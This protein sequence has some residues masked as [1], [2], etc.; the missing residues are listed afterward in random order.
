MIHTQNLLGSELLLS[1]RL[2]SS[3]ELLG[4]IEGINWAHLEKAIEDWAMLA[5]FRYFDVL[6]PLKLHERFHNLKCILSLASGLAPI[7]LNLVTKLLLKL[8][9]VKTVT[10]VSVDKFFANLTTDNMFSSFLKYH[11]FLKK[12]PR[13]KDINIELVNGKIEDPKVY[14]RACEIIKPSQFGCIFLSHPIVLSPKFAPALY[15]LPDYLNHLSENGCFIFCTYT[16]LECMTLLALLNKHYLAGKLPGFTVKQYHQDNI[17]PE[18][19][20]GTF[21]G[22]PDKFVS[23]LVLNT[24]QF[25]NKEGSGSYM[26]EIYQ[27][28]ASHVVIIGRA[29]A[30][31]TPFLPENWLLLFNYRKQANPSGAMHLCRDELERNQYN[32]HLPKCVPNFETLVEDIWTKMRSEVCNFCGKAPLKRNQCSRCKAVFYCDKTCQHND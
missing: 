13:F 27:R 2:E 15:A 26:S 21:Q 31:S 23:E 3:G 8:E 4:L 19:T 1:R 24:K 20:G 22:W 9:S 28:T 6:G 10:F 30:G 25:D 18:G 7:E 12:Q 32:L 17:D 16:R 29:K 11:A 14:E 5:L